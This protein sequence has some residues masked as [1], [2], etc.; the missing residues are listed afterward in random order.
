[1]GVLYRGQGRQYYY[2][3][4]NGRY[5][6]R[7][8]VNVSFVLFR[9]L[10]PRA[11]AKTTSVPI[12]RVVSGLLRVFYDFQGLVVEGA[13][14]RADCYEVRLEGRPL[15]RGQWFI[16]LRLMFYDI[17]LI[18][19]YVGCRRHVNV[20]RHSRGLALALGRGLTKRSL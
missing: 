14:V 19:V 12:A 11:L 2:L 7:Y 4:S 10:Y 20:P 8:R 5:Y 13:F 6:V 3:T 18:G 15:V 17:G 1:M 9:A 16:V